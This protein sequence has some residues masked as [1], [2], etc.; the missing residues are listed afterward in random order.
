MSQHR[1]YIIL[2]YV[3]SHDEAMHIVNTLLDE[4]LIAC[5]NIAPSVES[6]YTWKNQ[7]CV[8][9]ETPIWI[10][11]T[12]SQLEAAKHRLRALHPYETPALI[13]WPV[14][15]N[16]DYT[17]WAYATTSPVKDTSKGLHTQQP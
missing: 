10:K 7:K 13:D 4:T 17:T 3:S 2:T 15:T 16:S 9:T 1:I 6:H 11:T 8:E 14:N 12:A 5:A